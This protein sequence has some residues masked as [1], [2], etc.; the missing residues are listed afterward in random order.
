MRAK[1]TPTRRPV[2]AWLEAN[3]GWHSVSYISTQVRLDPDAV[4]DA[5]CKLRRAGEVASKPNGVRR[6]YS[7]VQG[8]PDQSRRVGKD[9]EA[10]KAR[11]KAYFKAKAAE[12]RAERLA[13]MEAEPSPPS[14]PE[15]PR[16]E[17]VAEFKARGGQVETLPVHWR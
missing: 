4:T 6:L 10:K 8:A 16:A 11:D 9:M 5:L 17:T 13:R 14:E 2:R 15:Q 3:P 7:L 1:A 12:L